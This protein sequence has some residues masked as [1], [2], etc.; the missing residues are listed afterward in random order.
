[1]TRRNRAIAKRWME[2]ASRHE[3]FEVMDEAMLTPLQQDI[4]IMKRKNDKTI[5]GISRSVKFSESKIN[6]EIAKARES[7]LQA[8]KAMG[9][10]ESI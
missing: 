8:L 9:K 10:L 4:I 7:I 3:L 5:V 6:K 1:M 2:K